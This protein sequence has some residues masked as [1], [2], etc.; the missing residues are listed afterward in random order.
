MTQLGHW[1]DLRVVKKVAFGVYLDDGAGH[2]ILLPAKEVPADCE[3]GQILKVFIY[4]DSEDRTIATLERPAGT[5]GEFVILKVASVGRVGA[6]L[7]WGLPKDLLLPYAEQSRDLR[8]G[9]EIIAYIY[10]D[11]SGRLAATMRLE[12]NLEATPGDLKDGQK[13]DLLLIGKTDLGFKAII[14]GKYLGVLYANEVFRRLDYGQRTEGY[15]KHVRPDGKIDLALQLE[16]LAGRDETAERILDL[17]R[18]QNGFLHVNDK[19]SPETIYKLFGVSKKKYKIALGGLYKKRVV[20]VTDEGVF[21]VK[22]ADGE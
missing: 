5:V 20:R 2:E 9:Q 14:N 4:Q 10:V 16:G 8:P 12:R 15:V 22:D 19:T 6:F 17:L 1:N 13:V 11:K 7:D 3:I 21:L 18:K